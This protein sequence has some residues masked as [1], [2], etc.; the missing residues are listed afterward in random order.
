MAFDSFTEFYVES[1]T[2]DDTYGGSSAFG[3]LIQVADVS[4]VHNGLGVHTLTDNGVDG[5]AGAA[6]D[7]FLC[8]DSA[9]AKEFAVVTSVTSDD[10]IVVQNLEGAVAFTDL[11][12]V[13]VNIGG[14]WEHVDHA[15][16]K[17]ATFWV[18]NAGDPPRVNIGPGT[19]AEEVTID[20]AG[21]AAVP[22]TFEGYYS[23]VGDE[24]DNAGTFTPP[25]IDGGAGAGNLE[26]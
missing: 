19:Y 13:N 9:G 22:L 21:T 5:F 4:A 3:S 14:P 16:S 26:I 6:Q 20:N 18:N 10:V 25:T 17:V 11:T 7:D 1:A 2:S 24:C 15:A 8:Y 12:N 23:T